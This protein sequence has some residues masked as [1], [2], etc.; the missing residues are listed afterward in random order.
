MNIDI[1]IDEVSSLNLTD[2]TVQCLSSS[3]QYDKLLIS[4][5]SNALHLDRF[6][7]GY[8]CPN[9]YTL[10]NISDASLISDNI[11]GKNVFIIGASFIGMEVASCITDVCESV[12]VVGMEMVPFERILGPEV[13]H[14]LQQWHEVVGNIRFYLNRTVSEFK[15][16]QNGN[17]SAV[18]LNDGT[19][20][21]TDLIIVG[22]GAR[23]ATTFLKESNF[24]LEKDGSILVDQYLRTEYDDVF[25][26]GDITLFPHRGELTKIGHWGMSQNQ[27]KIAA[28]N[29]MATDP[30]ETCDNIPFFWTVQYGSSIRFCGNLKH[31]TKVMLIDESESKQK[32]EFVALYFCNSVLEAACSMNRDPVCADVA[33]LLNAGVKI[34]VKDVNALLEDGVSVISLF[35]SKL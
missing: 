28:L 3:I 34:T 30:Q 29:M 33:E 17:A 13:G 4:T 32:P 20:I 25:A 1:L 8:D 24:R 19:E 22:A 18:V 15:H 14:I 6:V 2:K 23:P 9:V 11:H 5:G 10:R 7:K 12:S 26:A 31:V 21:E 35:E 16:N 27:G